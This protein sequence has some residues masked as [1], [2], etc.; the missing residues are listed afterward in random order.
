MNK[1]NSTTVT[2]GLETAGLSYVLTSDGA[3]NFSVLIPMAT[4]NGD[5]ML[6]L[7]NILV[8]GGVAMDGVNANWNVDKGITIS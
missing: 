4:M 6:A 1:A 7:V 2:G 3:G 5:Q 8:P